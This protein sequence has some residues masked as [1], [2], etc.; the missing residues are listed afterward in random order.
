Q[1]MQ[2]NFTTRPVLID[3]GYSGG[4]GDTEKLIG[5]LGADTADVGLII[6][7][8]CHCDHTGGN[9]IIQDR[10][11]CE[12]ALHPLGRYFME[13]RDGWSTWWRYY[14]QEVDFFRCGTSLADGALIDIGPHVFQII[15][16]PGHSA[17]GLALYNAKEKAL[18]SGDALWELDVPVMTVRIEGSAAVHHAEASLQ[19]LALLDVEIVYPGHGKP[20]ADFRG[21]LER[22]RDKISAYLSDRTRIGTDLIK[23]I[24]VFTLLMKG[25]V[26]EN[27]FFGLLM[28][29]HWYRETVDLYFDASYEET[30]DEIITPFL[31][32]GVVKCENGMLFTGVQP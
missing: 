12:V 1:G 21:A 9:R 16:T 22:S 15:H 18:I 28:D 13:T 27:H 14:Q 30:Y 19:K 20:F 4:F 31:R 7:T 24:I 17:D 8:H 26:P 10:S 25:R 2:R 5:A 11:G 6:N 29:T 3:T 23:K 32:R